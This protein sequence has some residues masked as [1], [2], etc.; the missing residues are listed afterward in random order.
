M[1]VMA[2]NLPVG[3][4]TKQLGLLVFGAILVFEVLNLGLIVLESL[5]KRGR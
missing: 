5:K 1:I 4:G 3:I 2:F